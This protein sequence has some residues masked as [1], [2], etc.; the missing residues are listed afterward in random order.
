MHI[1]FAGFFIVRKDLDKSIIELNETRALSAR[2]WT[3]LTSAYLHA[4]SL[5]EEIPNF[6]HHVYNINAKRERLL[7]ESVERTLGRIILLLETLETCGINWRIHTESAA[8]VSELCGVSD[9][10]LSSWSTSAHAH[11][12]SHIVHTLLPLKERLRSMIAD[13]T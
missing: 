13:T 8:E 10:V 4:Q 11:N 1:Y 2:T 12:T 5:L 3:N 7:L 9:W 6:Y